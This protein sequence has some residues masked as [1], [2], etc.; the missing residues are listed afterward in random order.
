MLF[1]PRFRRIW[2]CKRICPHFTV[3]HFL[4]LTVWLN[5]SFPRHSLQDTTKKRELGTY[6]IFQWKLKFKSKQIIGTSMHTI[7]FRFF[8]SRSCFLHNPRFIGF[9]FYCRHTTRSMQSKHTWQQ[10][11]IKWVGGHMLLCCWCGRLVGCFLFFFFF[12]RFSS[13]TQENPRRWSNSWTKRDTKD[14]QPSVHEGGA[15]AWTKM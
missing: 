12:E 9:F 3:L 13:W 8:V 4:K 14:V 6:G 10:G 11:M 15:G 2:N 1:L 7:I 5:K